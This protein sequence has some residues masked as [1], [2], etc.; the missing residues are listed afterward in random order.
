MISISYTT[1]RGAHIFK[2]VPNDQ[3]EKEIKYFYQRKV[4]ADAYL[5]DDDGHKIMDEPVGGVERVG[6][7]IFDDKRLKWFWWFDSDV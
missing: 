6:S 3:L 5:L 7:G 1:K 4:E 2:R